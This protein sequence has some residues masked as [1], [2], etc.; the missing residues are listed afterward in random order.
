MNDQLGWLPTFLLEALNG[1]IAPTAAVLPAQ[2]A[3]RKQTRADA[4]EDGR[5]I[6]LDARQVRLLLRSGSKPA[7]HHR[8]HRFLRI[9]HSARRATAGIVTPRRAGNE[10]VA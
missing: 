7:E 10:P 8:L 9:L 1:W 6:Q 3:S 2:P 5:L 4:S